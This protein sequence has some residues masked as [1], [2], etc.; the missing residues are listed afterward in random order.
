MRG[1]ASPAAIT[2]TSLALTPRRPHAGG[3][4]ATAVKASRQGA[5]LRTGHVFCSARV[6]GRPLEILSRRL[7]AGKAHCR[8]AVPRGARG[9]TVRGVVIV[10]RGT[11]RAEARFRSK[12][13]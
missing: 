8:W 9:A 13:S 11:V 10:Q 12:I 6:H 5:Q 7:R 1:L 2:L 4:L 3:V